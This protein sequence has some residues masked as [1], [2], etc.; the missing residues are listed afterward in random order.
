MQGIAGREG[1]DDVDSRGRDG[2]SIDKEVGEI[3]AP[4]DTLYHHIVNQAGTRPH[5]ATMWA[6]TRVLRNEPPPVIHHHQPELQWIP[7][8]RGGAR[9]KHTLKVDA[10]GLEQGSKQVSPDARR[11]QQ[12]P[13]RRS[14]RLMVKQQRAQDC[15]NAQIRHTVYALGDLPGKHLE[16]WQ[17]LLY[18]FHTDEV[19]QDEVDDVLRLAQHYLK[20]RTSRL[21]QGYAAARQISKRT[22]FVTT[23]GCSRGWRWG[24]ITTSL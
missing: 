9:G 18:N 1:G 7:G 5:F 13:I 22:A 8:E 2:D 3:S 15:D 23:A 12:E 10:A 14:H 6:N 19:L 17:R 20:W 11:T 16:E 4:V 21:G 24:A